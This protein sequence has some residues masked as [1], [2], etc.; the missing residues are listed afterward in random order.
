MITSDELDALR[1]TAEADLTDLATIE[2]HGATED[3]YGGHTSGWTVRAGGAIPARLGPPTNNETRVFADQFQ[4]E[5]SA[6][7]TLPWDT[8]ISERARITM[9]STGNTYEVTAVA[10]LGTRST[11][12]RVLVKEA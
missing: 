3:E 10:P 2:D 1:E 6:V 7:V 8:E 4:S 9:E 11:V 5:A 12:Q